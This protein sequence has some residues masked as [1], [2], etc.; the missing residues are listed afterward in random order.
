MRIGI[1]C[2]GVLRVLAI[3]GLKHYNELKGEFK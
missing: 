1:D 2:D 3:A